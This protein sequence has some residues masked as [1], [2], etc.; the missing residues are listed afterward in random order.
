MG[1]NYRLRKILKEPR[2]AHNTV[3][4]SNGTAEYAHDGKRSI[5]Y[6]CTSNIVLV[7]LGFVGR[8]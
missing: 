3:D 5:L 8:Q 6:K 2:T 1:S 7:V 4:T